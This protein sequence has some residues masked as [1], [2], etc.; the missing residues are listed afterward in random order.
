MAKKNSKV[1]VTEDQ[2]RESR[3]EVL[4]RRKQQEQTRR[5]WIAVWGVLGLL[6]ALLL[7][8][9]ISE[10]FISP[11]RAVAEVSGEAIAL[12][13]WQERVEYERAQRIILLNNQ[14][15]AF[16][17]DVGIIQQFSGQAINE[18]V[19]EELLGQTILNL[20]VEELAIQQAAEARGIT[21]TDAEIDAE[22]GSL[23]NYFGG[24][25]PTPLP[26]ATQTVEPTP[27]V[28]PIPT[29]VITDVLPTN[30][31]F[32]TPTTGPTNTPAPTATAVSAASFEEQFGDYLV[33]FQDL[34]VSEE[35]YRSVVRA[36][37]FREK[38]ADALA[39]EQELPTEAEHLSFFIMAFDNEE[40]AATWQ[41]RV[42]EVGYLT[43]WN[44]LRSAPLD[45]AA[46]ATAVAAEILWRTQT[47]LEAS[48]GEEVAQSLF[49]LALDE[50]SELLT[51]TLEDGTT[52]YY[53]VMNSG[54]EVR[55][56]TEAAI[57]QAKLQTLASFIDELL[58]GNLVMTGYDA[59]RTPGTPRLD[60][61]FLAQP[62]ATPAAAG[63][64]VT[65]AP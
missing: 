13:Q 3:K 37:L 15:E 9:V 42:A 55:P 50:P 30:T 62:T 65:P 23:F 63:V 11:S 43:A 52:R 49:D 41:A 4:I 6:G 58:V 57:E 59:G 17:G 19:S 21:V 7:I 27:S 54:K 18:L 1:A 33:Q 44:E 60:P 38:L 25:A 29:A 31:P 56:L 2:Q 61:K 28:T 5:V 51:Q 53:L 14:L 48:F 12:R 36:Q 47:D 64:E 32:P 39:V 10:I 34:G 8:A 40:E 20:M 24:E 45:E 22:I 46:A 16:G 26:T 35:L